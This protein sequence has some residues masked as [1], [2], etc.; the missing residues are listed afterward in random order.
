MYSALL[1]SMVKF[2]FFKSTIVNDEYVGA[3]LNRIQ[4]DKKN[5]LKD[6]LQKIENKRIEVL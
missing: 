1:L 6:D 2:V 4:N 3:S 5:E